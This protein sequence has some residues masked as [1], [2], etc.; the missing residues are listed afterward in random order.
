MRDAFTQVEEKEIMIKIM[1]K[2]TGEMQMEKK[3]RRQAQRETE[4]S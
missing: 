1:I 3:K 4:V 2:R